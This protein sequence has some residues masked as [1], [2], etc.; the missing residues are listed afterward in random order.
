MNTSLRK[1]LKGVGDLARAPAKLA[2][3]AIATARALGNTLHD[4]DNI[5][6][7]ARDEYAAAGA[8]AAA[9]LRG[10]RGK[11]EAQKALGDGFAA[12]AALL[13]AFERRKP[14]SV[15]VRP[16]QSLVEVA[17]RELG[18]G[19][20]WSEIAEKNE[21]AGQT[22]PAGMFVVDLPSG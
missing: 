16:G 6:A 13:D 18:S 12:V 3:D 22:V 19:D 10:R 9:L 17:K 8:G 21:I 14:R 1:T 4:L 2:N 15:G 20:R 5:I 7:D 11:G